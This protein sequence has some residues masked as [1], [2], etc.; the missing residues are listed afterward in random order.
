MDY[1]Y[2]RPLVYRE[3]TDLSDFD[4]D[5]EKS[6]NCQLY[7]SLLTIWQLNPKYKGVF[8]EILRLFNDAYFYLT[9]IFMAKRPLEIY[10]DICNDA[11]AINKDFDWHDGSEARELV[12]LCM[13][14]TLL[15]TFYKKMTLPQQK[16][17][18]AIHTELYKY[19]NPQD[20][21]IMLNRLRGEEEDVVY[22]IIGRFESNISSYSVP[23]VYYT[24]RNI[25]EVID[26]GEDLRTCLF[27]GKSLA[28]AVEILCKRKEQ[29]LQLIS[30][31][32]EP[33]KNGY[34]LMDS[35]ISKAYRSLYELRAELTG[36]PLS[37]KL[38]FEIACEASRPP[39]IP[40]LPPLSSSKD[41]KEDEEE[42]E[43]NDKQ[44]IE[45]LKAKVEKQQDQIA[46]LRS[47]N[48]ELRQ[49]LAEKGDESTEW[50]GCFDL[51]FHNSLNP[52]AIANALNN[53]NHPHFPKNER[54]Y[55]WVFATVLAEIG[56]IPKSNYKMTLQWANLHFK[57]GWDW[58]R[59]NQ[60]KFNDINKSI[61]AV[62]PSSK[63][64][65]SITGN[66]IGEY[67]GALA[68]IMRETFTIIVNGGK[69]MDR[70]EFIKPGCPLI[71]NGR[72]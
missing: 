39:M 49:R 46:S 31:L 4:I 12:I 47:E 37:E 68:E 33:E 65:K 51:F 72:K 53:I 23:K 19:R 56:W 63:W 58:A 24:P 9:I 54:G 25:Q 43:D 38:P 18:Q 44:L 15:R 61:R 62:Q 48:D 21:L 11:G 2:I 66:V 40:S 42:D 59:D 16:L 5:N 67:Y 41:E 71:N 36:E 64:D 10:P 60:F 3:I 70:K 35:T 32:L 14:H 50:I 26:S 34:G 45:E 22:K 29:K 17:V 30:R 27:A 6:I 20:T 57:C 28:T 69:L 1:T 13:L 52:Q 7:E 8:S 55:W